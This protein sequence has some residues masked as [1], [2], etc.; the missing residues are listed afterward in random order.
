MGHVVGMTTRR[1]RDHRCRAVARLRRG[2]P[3]VASGSRRTDDVFPFEFDGR[4][5]TPEQRASWKTNRDG[6]ERLLLRGSA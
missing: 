3:D 2:Q 1:S 5:F 4:T 6:M